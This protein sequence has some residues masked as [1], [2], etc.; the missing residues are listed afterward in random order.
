MVK[1]ITSDIMLRQEKKA[2]TNTSHVV[3]VNRKLWV[4]AQNDL[5]VGELHLIR[6]IQENFHDGQLLCYYH[7]TL[8]TVLY[9]KAEGYPA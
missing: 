4:I 2:K 8:D 5:V 1:S 3:E 9:T 6:Q 7:H